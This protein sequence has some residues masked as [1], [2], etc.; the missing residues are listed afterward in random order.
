[1]L[2]YLDEHLKAKDDGEDVVAGGEEGSLGG[3]WGDVGA[4]HGQGDAVEANE[5]QH[6][7]VEVLLRYHVFAE[8]T[9][10]AEG[11]R[12]EATVLMTSDSL[13]ILLPINCTRL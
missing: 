9:N 10:S 4:L 1:M 3:V 7:A 12:S 6:R 13:N 2:D 11:R 8:A 5:Q